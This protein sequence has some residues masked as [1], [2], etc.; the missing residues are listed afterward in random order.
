MDYN[1]KRRLDKLKYEDFYLLKVEKNNLEYILTLTGSTKN[2]YQVKIL[3]RKIECK[4]PDFQSW[5]KS[6]NCYCKH[7][8]FILYKIFYYIFDNN[9]YILDSK[10][11]NKDDYL[12]M[13]DK[14]NFLLKDDN[15]KELGNLF[16]LELLEKFLKYNS[17]S[18]FDVKY[19]NK[20]ICPIC[21][22]DLDDNILKCPDCGI[23]IHRLC[24]EK[25]IDMGNF[26]CVYCRSSVWKKYNKN[27]RYIS[28][29]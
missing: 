21:Y 26:S 24:M 1:Q 17:S 28:L 18:F 23:I 14:F 6:Y 5:C 7:I 3:N 11:I 20:E 27:Q 4:C 15:I 10:E 2:I 8:C 13:E 22:M 19:K 29:E 25:W 9:L 16:N 12:K